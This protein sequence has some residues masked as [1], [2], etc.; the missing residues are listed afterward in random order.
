MRLGLHLPPLPP[1]DYPKLRLSD[2]LTTKLGTRYCT[3]N[4]LVRLVL[5]QKMCSRVSTFEVN[6]T[7]MGDLSEYMEGSTWR[8]VHGGEYMEGSTWR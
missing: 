3:A 4:E 6:A 8:G 2:E 7:L 5:S 1:R